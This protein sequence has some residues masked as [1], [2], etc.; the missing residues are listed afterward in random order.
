MVISSFIHIGM[1]LSSLSSG[2]AVGRAGRYWRALRENRLRPQ[3]ER[4]GHP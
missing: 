1:D 2:Q 3:R 4:G